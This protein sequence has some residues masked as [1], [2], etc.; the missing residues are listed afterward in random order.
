MKF[1]SITSI[2]LLDY[3]GKIS[4]IIFTPGCNFRC[5]YCYN[6]ELVLHPERYRLITEAQA[7]RKLKKNKWIDAVIVTGGEPTIHKDLP[8]FL[9]KIKKETRLLI[10]L[11]TNGSNPEMLEELMR[12]KLVDYIAMDIKTAL[13]HG[14]Y[15]KAT[16]WRAD[17]KKI[18]KSISLIIKSKIK[19]EFRT[20]VVPGIVNTK[21]I[22]A[23]VK[24]IKG[25]ED[26]FLQQFKPKN[27]L[28][29]EY[30]KLKPYKNSELFE[31]KKKAD[32]FV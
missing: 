30:E 17:I 19:H 9:K 4:S 3:P 24:L 21:D 28:N 22:E 11:E 31:M 29:K 1:A 15:S 14:D 32:K 18:K 8:S 26:Y 5:P 7:I 27:T 13:N 20:T 25:E 12:K 16:G 23:I 6:K 10:G 2:S